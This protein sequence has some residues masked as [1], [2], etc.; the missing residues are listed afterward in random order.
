[1]NK[2]ERLK[3]ILKNL[4]SVVLAYSGGVDS[5]FLLKIASDSLPKENLLAVTAVSETYTG[6]ELIQAK[7]I[8]KRLGVRHF[9]IN[10]EELLNKNFKSNP[11]DRCYYCKEELFSRL[12]EIA[13]SYGI[14]NVIDASNIDDDKDYRPGRK[15]KE[16]LSVR[17]PLKEAGFAK[18]EIRKYSKRLGLETWNYPQ[19]ACLASRFPYG[20]KITKKKLKTVEQA[21][22]FLRSLGVKQVRARY[23]RDI[24]RIEVTKGDIDRFI[25]KKFRNKVI[26]YL[27][28]LGF[29]YIVLDLEGYRSGSLNEIL[30]KMPKEF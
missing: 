29:K 7:R 18:S 22:D 11:V 1:M 23:H 12:K 27:K 26:K 20:E 6:S 9:I 14:Q 4:K 5:S 2:L 19:M 21:E 30:T 24:V 10:T 15:A 8:A 13:K 25:N 28:A 16:E 3:N 17:S